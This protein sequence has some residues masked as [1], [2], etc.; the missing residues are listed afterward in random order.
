LAAT[1]ISRTSAQVTKLGR[2]TLI[3]IAPI[4][5]MTAVAAFLAIEL[6]V[7]HAGFRDFDE[8]VYWQSLRAL[9][10]GEPLFG[11]VFASQPPAFYYAMLPFYLVGH[12][13]F[14]LRIGVLVLSAAGLAFGHI[15]GHRKNLGAAGPQGTLGP[16]QRF[17]LHVREDNFHA[18]RGESFR[19][20][21]A[22]TA[23]CTSDDRDPT[24]QGFHCVAS[25][26]N[27]WPLPNACR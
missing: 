17:D 9:G 22:D 18:F 7:L 20:G 1:N 24:F 25:R 8:G 14:A 12:S 26:L 11:T 10:R 16:A 6:S 4:L 15:G 23:C 5:A 3:W 13:I 21:Q 2:P 19:H 27:N